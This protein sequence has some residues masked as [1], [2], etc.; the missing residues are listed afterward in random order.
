VLSNDQNVFTEEGITYLPIY[1]VMFFWSREA[2]DA[3]W[4]AQLALEDDTGRFGR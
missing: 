4:V 1:Y 3:A 2:Y